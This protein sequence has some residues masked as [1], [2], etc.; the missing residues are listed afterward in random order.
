MTWQPPPRP[1]WVRAVNSGDVPP[2]ADVAK[3]PLDRDGLLDEARAEL[4]ID[5]RG[6]E[7]F[8]DSGLGDDGFLEPLSVLLP[9]LEEEA[10]LT[11]LGRWITRRFLL[12]LLEVRAQTVAYVRDDPGVRDEVIDE[13][14]IVTGAPRTGTTILHALLAQ[15]PTSRVPEGWE[16]LRPVPP[17]DPATF[18][19]EARVALADRE[20]RMPALATGTLDAI[21]EYGGR[22]HKECVSSM[23]FEFRSE[24]FTA[25]YHVPSYARWLGSCDM[26]PAYEWHRLVLQILQR[27]FTGTRW[28]LKSPVHLH[29]LATLFAV[30]PDARLAVTHRDPLAVLG[31]VTSLVATM[32]WAHS[33]EVD[34]A[35]IGRYHA[36]LYSGALDR[37]VD[38]TESGALDG[39]HVH[40]TH[41]AEFMADPLVTVTAVA[42]GLGTPVTNETE[43]AM[44]AYLD[45]HPQGAHGEHQ[46]SFDDLHVDPDDMRARFSRY[47]SSFDVLREV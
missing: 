8:A 20:L 39:A 11:V 28:V 12:R 29:S 40:H 23:S 26:A 2:I 33:D 9:A 47:Q 21:H 1:D 16:L 19:D 7:G 30:Y 36:D 25:R 42:D 10:Q 41:Y 45:A 3:L 22:M 35:D 44:R 43:Q 18:P 13:P 46:Y 6:V 27:R 5:G 24:E 34:F 31:S 32:R 14:V 15:D 38:L 37:L 17:P 4:A